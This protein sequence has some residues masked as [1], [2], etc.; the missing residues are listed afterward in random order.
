MLVGRPSGDRLAGRT[1]RGRGRS[2]A[3][4]T[5]PQIVS[6]VP[7]RR[8]R[9]STSRKSANG[10]RG[11][12]DADRD[13]GQD[14]SETSPR[15]AP[16]ASSRAAAIPCVSGR[17]CPTTSSARGSSST[18][19]FTPQSSNMSE[20]VSPAMRIGSRDA[21]SRRA[22][23]EPERRAGRDDD[24]EHEEELR[25]GG[26]D[27]AVVEQHPAG[28]EADTEISRPFT[29]KR[30]G[31]TE[32]EREPVRGARDDEGQRP[33]EPVVRDHHDRPVDARHRAG[34]DGVAHDE[35]RVGLLAVRAA[36]V[37]EEDDLEERDPDQRGDEHRG[38]DPVEER[39][40]GEDAAEDE[41]ADAR[42]CEREGRPAAGEPQEE[43]REE[44]A[45]DE[46]RDAEGAARDD[47][48]HR[49][50]TAKRLFHRAQAPGR[51]ENP[52]DRL[53]PGRQ[54]G[55]RDEQAGQQPDG[56][57][58]EA[59]EDRR[60]PREDE[61]A[62]PGGRRAC[63]GSRWWRAP[64]RRRAAAAPPR[65]ACRRRSPPTPASP[66]ASTGRG[67]PSRA[68]SARARRRSEREPSRA[69]R[70][71][72][73]TAPSGA[74][75]P[76]RSRS[77][78]RRRSAQPRD[79]RRPSC[80]RVGGRRHVEGDRREDDRLDDGADDEEHRARQRSERDAPARD[81]EAQPH[82]ATS[83]R[84]S[85]CASTRSSPARA[86]APAR[87]G[88]AAPPAPGA[89]FGP[90]MGRSC[91]ARALRASWFA[92]ARPLSSPRSFARRQRCDWISS[93]CIRSGSWLVDAPPTWVNVAPGS[94]AIVQPV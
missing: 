49:V 44:R 51:R 24:D 62:T 10:D 88:A 45:E 32:E 87:G 94:N 83:A 78:T 16:V 76:I 1:P 17:I 59:R 34:L 89:R 81:E 52:A 39:A 6:S 4:V 33:E 84:P 41:D 69:A 93:P 20:Y 68:S 58:E 9:A 55:E 36:E 72:A 23:H 29:T 5:E 56:V 35:E 66:R 86:V 73:A 26:G 42:S 79:R 13:L 18:G 31:P 11:V 71:C 60:M 91:G 82:G 8:A 38:M 19:T 7:S 65:A 48:G 61:R 64:R 2:G 46:V 54:Q 21:Q 25:Q 67:S 80:S 63:R 12:G 3:S 40:V 70:A 90:R 43:V 74:A 85:R 50:A 57:A 27:R 30:K 15:S 75:N 77:P 14:R 53:D 37:D 92:P 47:L 28:Q 22:E